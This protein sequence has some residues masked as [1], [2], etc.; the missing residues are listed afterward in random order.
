[1]ENWSV[2]TGKPVGQLFFEWLRYVPPNP[3]ICRPLSDL[4]FWGWEIRYDESVACIRKGGII[5]RTGKSALKGK[6]PATSTS[7]QPKEQEP[8]DDEQEEEADEVL[9]DESFD[10]DWS[11]DLMCVADPFVVT[12]VR[13]FPP[14]R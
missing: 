10:A 13:T 9:P 11:R 3:L 1:V 5:P 12:K 6:G 7:T 4:R 14:L 8:P 2:D